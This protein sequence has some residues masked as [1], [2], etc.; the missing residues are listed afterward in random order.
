MINRKP[1]IKILLHIGL[2]VVAVGLCIFTFY[3]P[4]L[5][6]RSIGWKAM[7]LYFESGDPMMVHNNIR[8][9]AF[10]LAAYKAIF[11]L[12]SVAISILVKKFLQMGMLAKVCLISGGIGASFI[13]L[14]L[15]LVLHNF[16]III[17]NG[18]L[19]IIIG[20]IFYFHTSSP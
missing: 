3:V 11:P 5:Y 13:L 4:Y 17:Y 14:F 10:M 8:K 7:E 16:Q 20:W 2:Y 6:L 15:F 18:G 12:S 9:I 19:R 1:N